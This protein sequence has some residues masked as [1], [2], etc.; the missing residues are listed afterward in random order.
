MRES[1]RSFAL[2]LSSLLRSLHC[3]RVQPRCCRLSYVQAKTFF[4]SLSLSRWCVTA[5]MNIC[6]RYS[7]QWQ[8]HAS[9]LQSS[10]QFLLPCFP[11]LSLSSF[12]MAVHMNICSRCSHEGHLYSPALHSSHYA[13][14]FPWYMLCNNCGCSQNVFCLL[15]HLECSAHFPVVCFL[16]SEKPYIKCLYIQKTLQ[17]LIH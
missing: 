14:V 9:A 5:H 12:C 6:S 8:L 4:R 10:S 13:A 7:H 16:Q 1:S 15:W 2:R 3:M 11:G 17:L